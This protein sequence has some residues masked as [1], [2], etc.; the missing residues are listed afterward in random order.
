MNEILSRNE[1]FKKVNGEIRSFLP[2]DLKDLQISLDQKVE[3]GRKKEVLNVRLPDGKAGA[4]LGLPELYEYYITNV[5]EA[6]QIPSEVFYLDSMYQ[7]SNQIAVWAN[8]AM[9]LVFPEISKENYEE[10]K[11]KLLIQLVGTEG[12][13]DDLKD[14]PH[15]MVGGDLA[16]VYKMDLGD[17]E[18]CRRATI[19]N[20]ML[21]DLGIDE[22]KL[23]RDAMEM[24]IKNY[25]ATIQTLYESMAE[26]FPEHEDLEQDLDQIVISNEN[27][28]CGA[29]AFFYP[30]VMD[31][32]AERMNGSYYVLPSSIHE[33]IL[34]P[35]DVSVNA[36]ELE[37]MVKEINRIAVDPKDRLSDHVYHYDA[38]ERLFERSDEFELR[39]LKKEIIKDVRLE[40][41][42]RKQK[43]VE[44]TIGKERG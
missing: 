4:T 19:I 29:A 8:E 12:R 14:K 20:E 2:D 43:Q 32:A 13:E 33:L 44:K 27:K 37:Q 17:D 23:H 26:E 3:K 39:N 42:N 16:I 35:D 7:L 9:R 15:K 25:P 21:E 5:E 38:K 1:F 11:K 40:K 34:I 36:R 30:G 41:E 18:I 31:Q 6:P 24:S 22:E 10:V 28:I